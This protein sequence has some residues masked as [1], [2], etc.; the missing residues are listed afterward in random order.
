MLSVTQTTGGRHVQ[1]ED[2]ILLG[3]SQAEWLHNHTWCLICVHHISQSRHKL[4]SNSTKLW[5]QYFCSDRHEITAS[6]SDLLTTCDQ[7]RRNNRFRQDTLFSVDVHCPLLPVLGSVPAVP[8]QAFLCGGKVG[9]RH[10]P[11]TQTMVSFRL[12]IARWSRRF[13]HSPARRGRQQTT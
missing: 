13:H 5:F 11:R 2:D 8:G 3:L 4:Y 9:P 1:H 12:A 7:L 10:R 6:E